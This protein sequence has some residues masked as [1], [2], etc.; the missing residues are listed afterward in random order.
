MEYLLDISAI[1]NSVVIKLY[2]CQNLTVW[3]VAPTDGQL[4]VVWRGN[5]DGRENG[6]WAIVKG[7]RVE[8]WACK[9]R[10]RFWMELTRY[11][12]IRSWN[13]IWGER[14]QNLDYKCWHS[15]YCHADR[16][17][18][19]TGNGCWCCF[20]SMRWNWRSL[21]GWKRRKGRMLPVTCCKAILMTVW[22]WNIAP[23]V[24]RGMILAII[25]T[26][27]LK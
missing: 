10:P 25:P 18:L 22:F 20:I 23:K 4:V 19:W 1:M 15:G 8:L 9:P 16:L 7:K 12:W 14:E 17:Y 5:A 26:F 3:Q 27:C 11:W 21:W 6:S 13:G 24:I 2:L